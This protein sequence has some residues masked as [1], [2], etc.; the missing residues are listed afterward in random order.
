VKYEDYLV[1]LAKK[2]IMLQGTADRLT[3]IETCWEMEMNVGKTK[4]TRI[5]RQ[6]SPV[7]ILTNQKQIKNVKYFKY[8][9]NMVT[10][11]A[12]CTHEINCRIANAKAALNKITLFTSRLNLILRDKLVQC[13]IWNL[14]TSNIPEKLL[15]CGAGRWKRSV[16]A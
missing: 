12:I 8:L 15:T 13:Y 14:D 4:V 6:P 10:N 1:I 5:S 16:T 7:H 3:E 2:K 9:G 11:Y